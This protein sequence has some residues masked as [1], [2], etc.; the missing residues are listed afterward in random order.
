VGTRNSGERDERVPTKS[1]IDYS[2]VLCKLRRDGGAH[3]LL[4]ACETEYPTGGENYVGET[5][6]D[7]EQKDEYLFVCEHGSKPHVVRSHYCQT[8]THYMSLLVR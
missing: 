3:G 2:F 6:V 1:E 7:S 4:L 8:I 5:A